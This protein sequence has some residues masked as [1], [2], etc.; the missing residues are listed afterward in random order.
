VRFRLVE[1]FSFIFV[2]A[3]GLAALVRP[4][5]FLAGLFFSFALC[6][7]LAAV[8]CAIA[9][10][11]DARF[12]WIGLAVSAIAYLWCVK[13]PDIDSNGEPFLFDMTDSL[14]TSRCL[15]WFWSKT[16]PERGAMGREPGMMSVRSDGTAATVPNEDGKAADPFGAA[17]SHV[18]GLALVHGSGQSVRDY[19][20]DGFLRAGHCLWA[21][22]IGWIG[23]YFTQWVYR[24]SR[25]SSA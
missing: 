1:L 3:F 18:G 6:I 16:Q 19:S 14:A 20:Y 21:I 4:T 24:T 9:R 8:L 10:Q 25:K 7:L 23:G 2:L 11:G 5:E 17:T 15:N 13:A 22:I 12:F